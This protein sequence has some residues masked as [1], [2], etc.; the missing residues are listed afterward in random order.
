MDLRTVARLVYK[1]LDEFQGEEAVGRAFAIN[2]NLIPY[3]YQVTGIPF[4][5][6]LGWF[7][8]IGQELYWHSAQLLRTLIRDGVQSYQPEGI[9]LHV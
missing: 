4:T 3:L 2:V 1:Y 6:T 9:P 5:L 7:A 8:Q